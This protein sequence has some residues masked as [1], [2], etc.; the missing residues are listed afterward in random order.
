MGVETFLV[1]T[2]LWLTSWDLKGSIGRDFWYYKLKLWNKFLKSF[3]Q[4]RL[5]QKENTFFILNTI[6]RHEYRLFCYLN[7][8]LCFLPVIFLV[9][10]SVLWGQQ[11]SGCQFW[12]SSWPLIHTHSLPWTAE[13]TPNT[14]RK[15]PISHSDTGV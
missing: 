15:F 4:W 7:R 10:L 11:Q 14:S 13:H 12:P 2:T 3:K 5:C 1:F 6:V 8:K 9:T